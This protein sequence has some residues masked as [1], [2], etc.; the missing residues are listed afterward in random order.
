MPLSTTPTVIRRYIAFELRRLREAA[1]LNQ[2]EAAKRIDTT[3]GRIGHLET[4]R[5]LPK[6]P[7]IELLLP[8]YGAPDLVDGFQELVLQA[9]E[10]RAEVVPDESLPLPP[11]FDLYLGLEQGASRMFTYDAVVLNGIL[12]CRRYADAV[13][14]GQYIDPLSDGEGIDMVDLRM[15]RQEALDRA[16]SPLEVVAVIDEA[17]LRKQIGGPDVAAEQLGYLLV[18]SERPNVSIKVLS[19]AAGAHPGL[20]G[21]FIT[22][23]FPIERDPG[24]VYLEDRTGGRYQDDTGVIEDHARVADRLVELALSEPE[25]RS[26][27]AAVREEFS[28]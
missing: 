19:G 11:G 28:G 22:L 10:A 17:V 2:A 6:L 20:H 18:L 13:I 9:R 5:N 26:L 8:F 7:D 14:R 21:S 23:E 16:E 15:R 24:V 3:K 12:Q 27:I 25:S 4:G 1:G